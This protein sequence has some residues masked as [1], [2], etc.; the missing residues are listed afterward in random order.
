MAFQTGSKVRP[1]LGLANYSGITQGGQAMGQGIASFG[2]QIG[3]AMQQY[4]AN[5]KK[6]EENEKAFA[7]A[8]QLVGE[9]P[10]MGAAF[11]VL[12]EDGS[13]D[14]DKVKFLV[15]ELGP[16]RIIN[17]AFQMNQQA[18]QAKAKQEAQFQKEQGQKQRQNDISTM[19]MGLV[20]QMDDPLTPTGVESSLTGPV[21]PGMEVEAK[22]LAYKMSEHLYGAEYAREKMR[23]I[24][25]GPDVGVT[26]G[27]P[28]L[29]TSVGSFKPI[30]KTNLEAGKEFT[31]P[32]QS[33]VEQT[34][35]NQ[36]IFMDTLS[37][38]MEY[39]S[40]ETVGAVPKANRLV[41]DIFAAF[42]V[43]RTPEQLESMDAIQE[44]KLTVPQLIKNLSHESGGR[45]SDKDIKLIEKTF[46]NPDKWI[47]D[48]AK[49]K[50]SFENVIS[51][52]IRANETY[53]NKSGYKNISKN[54]KELMR[55]YQ[56]GVISRNLLRM[57]TQ[58][59]GSN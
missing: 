41:S 16:K 59:R 6:K 44:L 13:P 10:E 26:D 37:N 28:Y 43:D 31:K 20:K 21:D 42:G 2:Q 22:E 3:G 48:P 23:F 9:N 56:D 50:S 25:S 14:E 34:L 49:V 47:T 33:K 36:D 24:D 18:E 57:Y 17:T 5:K 39:I 35:M 11:Q 38:S 15:K 7:T 45:L 27:I 52:V 46:E 40:D 19:A 55:A 53:L 4:N 54:P 30:E 58:R 51:T 29:R 12:N 32:T 8:M 1:E